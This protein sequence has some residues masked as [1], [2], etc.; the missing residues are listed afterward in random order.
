MRTNSV[1]AAAAIA[2]TLLLGACGAVRA[3]DPAPDGAPPALRIGSTGLT[4]PEMAGNLASTVGAGYRVEGALPSGPS[5][6]PT[7]LPAGGT[8]AFTERLAKA[9]GMGLD[10]P[11]RHAHGWVVA[12]PDGLLQVADSGQWAFGPA[13]DPCPPFTVSVDSAGASGGVAC[14]TIGVV[15]SSVVGHSS[16]AGRPASPP[17]TAPSLPTAPTTALQAVADPVLSALGPVSY[18]HLTLPTKRIV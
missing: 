7:Y 4:A 10:I 9:L 5:R 2:S 16:T 3:G 8:K 6:A 12:S 13:A 15:Q 11:R 18:T 1:L 17:P 14:A